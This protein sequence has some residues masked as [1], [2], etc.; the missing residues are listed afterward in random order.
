MYTSHSLLSDQEIE[1]GGGVVAHEH[2]VER[3]AKQDDF[4]R[5]LVLIVL[6]VV[7]QMVQRGV[8]GHDLHREG[9]HAQAHSVGC[10][11]EVCVSVACPALSGGRVWFAKKVQVDASPMC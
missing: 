1:D 2:L 10:L 7:K 3:L 5:G 9:S 6:I 8:G 11:D 4:K